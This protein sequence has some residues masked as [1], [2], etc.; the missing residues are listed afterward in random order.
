MDRRFSIV[1]AKNKLPA[2][3][4][5]VEE[6]PSVKLTRNGKPVAVLLS[7]DEYERLTRKKE[8]FW[9]ALQKFRE[10]LEKEKIEFTEADFESLRDTSSGRE[11]EWDS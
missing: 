9:A 6:G 3:I 2:I 8:G 7:I 10:I 11:S 1:E 5:S 4:H